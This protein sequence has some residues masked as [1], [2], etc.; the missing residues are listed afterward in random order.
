MKATAEMSESVATT[1]D[2]VTQFGQQSITIHGPL[3]AQWLRLQAAVPSPLRPAECMW[4]CRVL[5]DALLVRRGDDVHVLSH[6]GE[7]RLEAQADELLQSEILDV[8]RHALEVSVM[9]RFL[10]AHLQH[11]LQG[12]VPPREREAVDLMLH[13]MDWAQRN[14]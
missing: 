12:R 3:L 5:A 14:D 2:V 4:R 8:D 1:H 9:V 11:T 13:A 6:M 7:L 10:Q